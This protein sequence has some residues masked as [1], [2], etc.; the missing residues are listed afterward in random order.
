MLGLFFSCLF[1]QN[2]NSHNYYRKLWTQCFNTLDTIYLY[3][4]LYIH[5]K[6]SNW[7]ENYSM[8]ASEIAYPPS[9]IFFWVS[10]YFTTV[11]KKK[12]WSIQYECYPEVLHLS[13]DLPASVLSVHCHS[14]PVAFWVSKVSI[15]CALHNL[16]RSSAVLWILWTRTYYYGHILFFA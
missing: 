15:V 16:A 9:R 6:R 3:I 11:K 5:N 13:C 2:V 12:V 7:W 1:Y 4:Y 10:N 14:S 8:A